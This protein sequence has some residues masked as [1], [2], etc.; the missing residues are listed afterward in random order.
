MKRIA[1]AATVVAVVAA[2]GA[3]VAWRAGLIGPRRR[4]DVFDEADVEYFDDYREQHDSEHEPEF[5][6]FS[7]TELGDEV[8]T[9]EAVV[10]E[11]GSLEVP[12]YVPDALSDPEVPDAEP[13]I[14]E[15]SIAAAEAVEAVQEVS[16]A[17]S[18]PPLEDGSQ[19]EGFPIKGNA[20]SMLY[21][22]PGSRH[23]ERTKAEVWF[24]T[25]EDA[26]AAGFA[27]PK[28]NKKPE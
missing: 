14:E 19:P 28:S 20:D 11:I 10:D 3:A 25:A 8:E 7:D 17:R 16:E 2:V 4:P 15:P 6:S 13:V 26:E 12:D 27:K 24:A 23:Y 21:H 1:T 18:H 9:D 22:E 5:L